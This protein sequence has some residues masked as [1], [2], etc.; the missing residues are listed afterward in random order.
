[1]DQIGQSGSLAGAISSGAFGP[2]FVKLRNFLGK[3]AH[4]VFTRLRFGLVF[5][6]PGVH[7]PLT[8]YSS[9]K[10]KSPGFMICRHSA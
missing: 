10:Y 2:S 3:K 4:W 5:G 6:V 8:A 1:M 9:S 7:F